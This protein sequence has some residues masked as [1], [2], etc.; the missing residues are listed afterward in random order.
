[1]SASTVATVAIVT[2]AVA[3]TPLYPP[4]CSRSRSRSCSRSRS[5]SS[6]TR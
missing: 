2:V 1:L 4:S 5:R 3:Q 6:P